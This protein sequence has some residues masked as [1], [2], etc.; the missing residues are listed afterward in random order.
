MLCIKFSKVS[1]DI[2][3]SVANE[4]LV[5]DCS[6]EIL[7]LIAARAKNNISPGD[8]IS[9][10]VFNF[11]NFLHFSQKQIVFL[12]YANEIQVLFSQQNK[13]NGHKTMKIIVVKYGEI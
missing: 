8:H 3:S 4:A 12:L 7:E 13:R 10:L 11:L 5:N 6:F 1:Q 9:P 2:D